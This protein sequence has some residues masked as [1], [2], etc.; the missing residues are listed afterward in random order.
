MIAL[1]FLFLALYYYMESRSVAVYVILTALI[2]GLF[3]WQTERCR[4][5]DYESAGTLA[6]VGFGVAMVPVLVVVVTVLAVIYSLYRWAQGGV[7]RLK[8]LNTSSR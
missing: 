6:S 8:A 7:D 1:A 3:V 2:V 5:K 4:N